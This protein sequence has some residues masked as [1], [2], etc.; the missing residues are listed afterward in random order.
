VAKDGRT[1]R[2]QMGP[3]G[4]VPLWVLECVMTVV[5]KTSQGVDAAARAVLVYVVLAAKY[6]NREHRAWPKRE[7]LAE[8]SGMSLASL[9][10]ALRILRNAGA[11]QTGLRHR[12]D[13]SVMGLDY[14]LVQVEPAKAADHQVCA[15]TKAVDHQVCT[16]TIIESAQTPPIKGRTRSTRTRSKKEGEAAAPPAPPLENPPGEG[17]EDDPLEA[18]RL[19]WNELRTDPLPPCHKL[20]PTR[21]RLIRARLVEHTIEDWRGIFARLNQ[22]AF[23]RGERAGGWPMSFDQVIGSPDVALRVLEGQYDDHLS[24]RDR[25]AACDWLFRCYGSSRHCP[26]TP[27]CDDDLACLR[28]VAARL[29]ARRA[30]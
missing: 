11:I 24:D 5:R 21:R 18:F 12:A 10:R 29:R 22:S 7:L 4:L 27:T 14:L 15:D 19:A 3:F 13:G 26:H 20:T 16:D 2:S 17:T 23:C 25:A 6:A 8:V 9:A 1:I 28:L 30:S